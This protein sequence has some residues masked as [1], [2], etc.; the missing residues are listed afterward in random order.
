MPPRIVVIGSANV[1]VTAYVA[2]MPRAAETVFGEHADVGFGGKGA[3]QAV[4][5]RRCGGEVALVARLGE[6]LFA[7]ATLDHYRSLGLDVSRVKQVPGPSGMASILVEAGGGNRIIVVAG[8]NAALR[9]EDVDEAAPLLKGAGVLLLQLETPLD[10]VAHALR[11]GREWGVRTL[12]NPAPVA[13]GFDR[14]LL[15]QADIV[16]PNEIEAEALTGCAIGNEE[17]ARRAARLL[18]DAGPRL[19]VLTLGDRGAL[20]A[21]AAGMEAIPSFPVEA[22]DTTGA[23]D[24]FIGS[25]AVF[26]AEGA[27]ARDAARRAS[28]YAALSVTSPG[29]QKSFPD[30]AAF[31]AA[32]RTRGGQGA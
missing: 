3:N 11:R 19:V 7:A 32:W 22:R 26:L 5:A 17:Q 25:F 15:R 30:R 13:P 4:A 6:D 9:P 16:V 1:D 29:A 12:L 8:A 20:L 18:L 10:T 27:P 24:A 23:G 14:A 2:A 31:D 21:E 28:L